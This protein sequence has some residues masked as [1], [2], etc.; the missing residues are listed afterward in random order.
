MLRRVKASAFKATTV[1]PGRKKQRLASVKTSTTIDIT[2]MAQTTS[3]KFLGAHVSAAGGLH[4]SFLNAREIEANAFAL[5][6]KPRKWAYNDLSSSDIDTFKQV[7]TDSGIS[8]DHILPHGQYIVNLGNPDSEKR[9]KSLNYFIDD[10]KRCDALGLTLFNIHP[11]SGV[12]E[13]TQEEAIGH[14]ASCLNQALKETLQVKIVLETMAGQGSVIGSTFESLR[15]VIKLVQPEYKHRVGVCL[16]TCHVFAAGYDIRTAKAFNA[17]LGEFDRIV[18]LDKLM[19]VHLNDSKGDLGCCKD[20]HENIGKGKIGLEAFKFIMRDARFDGI[21]LVLET[22][23]HNDDFS[24]W[25]KE[26]ELLRGFE[27][28]DKSD[29]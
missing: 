17:T 27:G 14:I 29:E 20:R 15:D 18:G 11:G 22:P 13:C 6:I 4:R 2:P 8:P 10:L 24:V 3:K 7:M 28:I 1:E 12:G 16:D 9:T 21:P 19:G 25:K 26:I 5:F 23:I